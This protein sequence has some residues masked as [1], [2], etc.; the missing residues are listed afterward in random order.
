MSD[1]RARTFTGIFALII[2]TGPICAQNTTPST[3]PAR[4][5]EVVVT[6]TRIEESTNDLPYATAALNRTTLE[7]RSPR[8]LPDALREES[9][10][11]VQKTALGQGSPFIRGFTGCRTVRLIEGCRLNTS[12]FRDGPNQ[13]W[14]TVDPWSL[15]QLE[16]VKGPTSAQ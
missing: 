1:I 4:L 14:A 8:T 10:I 15:D 5:D 3:K 7:E 16:L 2:A 12:V 11:M 9:S 6:A 13:A